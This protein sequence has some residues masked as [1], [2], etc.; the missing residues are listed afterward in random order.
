MVGRNLARVDPRFRNVYIIIF[1]FLY[2]LPYIN[3]DP[4]SSS[5]TNN[6]YLIKLNNNRTTLYPYHTHH[7]PSIPPYN[8]TMIS[9]SFSAPLVLLSI[10]LLSSQPSSVFAV[11]K[12]TGNPLGPNCLWVSQI[13]SIFLHEGNAEKDPQAATCMTREGR[14]MLITKYK[15][16]KDMPDMQLM[17]VECAM[18]VTKATCYMYVDGCRMPRA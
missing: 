7:L 14:T 12:G 2:L 1:S 4:L 8:S 3:A 9:V 10:L 17:T 5:L 16:V 6:S 18:C 13:E 11:P 15:C